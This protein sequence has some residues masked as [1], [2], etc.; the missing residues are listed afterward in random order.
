MAAEI[1]HAA[2]VRVVRDAF[3]TAADVARAEALHGDASTR[4][5]V[6]VHLRGAAVGSAVAMLLGEGRFA[7]GSDELGRR[8]ASAELPFVNVGRWLAANDFPVPA[9]YADRARDEG[10]L[11]L[12]DVGDVTLWAAVETEP[13]RTEPLFAAAVDL[14]ARLQ[15]AGARHPDPRCV[16]FGRRFDGDVARAELDHFIDHGIETRHRVTLPRGERA[17]LLA[18]LAPLERPFV[19]GPFA[20][21]HRDYMAWN[22]HVQDGHLRMIDFQDALMAPDAF[23]LAQLLTDRT[24]IRRVGGSHADALIARFRDAMAGAGLPLTEGFAARYHECV[25]QH[26]LKVI[27]RFYLLEVVRGRP[28][29]LAYL[30]SVYAVG[31]RAFDALPD[32]ASARRHVARWVPELGPSGM[33]AG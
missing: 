20:L 19:D 28:G 32:L 13:A 9:L 18:E 17:D 5:Y 23:D 3:G 11:L 2:L 26:A 8:D 24:T 1:P 22:L 21:A 15:I 4:R 10:V 27:G 14:L 33:E 31:R 25:L 7:P 6:R 16:A 29:Y 30:P 12:E